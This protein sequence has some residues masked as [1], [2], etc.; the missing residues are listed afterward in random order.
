MTPRSALR[1]RAA[2]P[3]LRS[4]RVRTRVRARFVPTWE[5][6]VEGWTIN[7]IN[8]QIWRVVPQYDFND[9]LQEAFTYFLICCERY[10]EVLDP[11]H[12]MA[13]YKRCFLNRINDL[14]ARR[15]KDRAF[16]YDEGGG[17]GGAGPDDVL[18]MV[19]SPAMH[20][21][22]AELDA[23][24]EAASGPLSNL[25]KAV[26]E[27]P[28]ELLKFLRAETTNLRET[29]SIRLARLAGMAE[30]Q[31]DSDGTT[32]TPAA[33]SARL[34]AFR[35]RVEAWAGVGQHHQDAVAV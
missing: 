20:L 6:P 24:I 3:A 25:L 35:R 5:G 7:T 27:L 8:K 15:T 18:M 26:Q 34:V 29:T 17:D 16:S 10:P 23:D 14:A 2:V 9:L 1:I 28:E 31:S 22:Q 12:F 21:Q 32:E 11:P 33:H 19:R 13:L 4:V 30:V